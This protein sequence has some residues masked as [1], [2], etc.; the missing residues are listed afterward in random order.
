MFF[1]PFEIKSARKL[2]G[3][4]VELCVT[5]EADGLKRSEPG[6][7]TL[8]ADVVPD[9]FETFVPNLFGS[10]LHRNEMG[11]GCDCRNVNYVVPVIT[12]AAVKAARFTSLREIPRCVRHS[13]SRLL[14]NRLLR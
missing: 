13:Y 11:V 12:E 8:S 14:N 3:E 4:A 5:F 9:N 6:L 7:E 1:Q 10:S 2:D